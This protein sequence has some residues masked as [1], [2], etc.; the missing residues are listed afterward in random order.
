MDNVENIIDFSDADFFELMDLRVDY[1]F[2]LF[3]ATGDTCRLVSLLNA[4]FAN[5]QIPRIIKSLSV[6]TPSLEKTAPSDKLSVLD[7]LAVLDNGA[8]IC[9]E[10]HLYDIFEIKYK[11][12]RSWARVFGTELEPKQKYSMQKLVICI[13]FI[14][15]AVKDVTD[16]PIE[17]VHSLFMLME[18]DSHEVLLPEMELHFI[19]MK[20]FIKYC[21]ENEGNEADFDMF[22][23]WLML[24]TQKEIMNKDAIKRICAEE[25]FK[26]AMEELNRL[27]KDKYEKLAYQRRLDEL[28]TYN[29]TMQQVAENEAAYRAALAEKD[30]ALAEKDEALAE[31]DEEL[32]KKDAENKLLL[33]Q[34]KKLEK[35]L[36]VE[37]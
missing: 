20:A 16:S 9:I 36:G 8:S 33:A 21:E 1:A 5:K 28:Y 3:F 27:S 4:I 29:K 24:I 12:V 35:Q 23:K 26:D 6:A 10:M 22:T 25:E 11:Q 7:I 37:E 2:K 18:R 19:D 32:A 34:I 30:E 13:S 14:N 15:G 31:K 17:K